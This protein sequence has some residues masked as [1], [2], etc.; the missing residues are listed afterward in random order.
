M[1]FHNAWP[2]SAYNHPATA[3]VH[4]QTDAPQTHLG[5]FFLA[6]LVGSGRR[7]MSEAINSQ[8]MLIMVSNGE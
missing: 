8:E 3:A 7:M 1:N 5:F 4:H 2:N 6:I